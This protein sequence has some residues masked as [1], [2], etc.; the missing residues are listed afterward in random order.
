MRK[1]ECGLEPDPPDPG[2]GPSAKCVSAWLD[3]GEACE[4]FLLAGLRREIGPGG[5]LRRAYREWYDRQMEEHDLTLAR[6]RSR[7]GQAKIKNAE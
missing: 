1:Q 5:D 3:L 7:T 6:M 4:Q 2:P